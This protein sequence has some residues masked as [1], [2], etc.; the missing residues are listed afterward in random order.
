MQLKID[1]L[2]GGVT[3]VGLV[4]RLDIAGVQAI[5]LRFNALM[6][7][8]RRYV[9]DLAELEFMASMGLRMLMM[10]SRTVKAKGGG[11]AL[12]AAQPGVERVLTESGVGDIIGH[13]PTVPAAA[14]ALAA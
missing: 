4:G 13:F 14:A 2:D 12:A 3:C 8:D 10:A 9:I 1:E 11:F 6:K 5:E 7:G